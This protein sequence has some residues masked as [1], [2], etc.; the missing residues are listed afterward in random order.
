MK[1]V[2]SVMFAMLLVGYLVMA[3]GA[4]AEEAPESSSNEE[5]IFGSVPE[6]SD[7]LEDSETITGLLIEE[8]ETP[9]SES[10]YLEEDSPLT[11]SSEEQESAPSDSML[12]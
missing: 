6:G 1:K 12:N 7:D 8:T 10:P 4:I 3:S 5:A 9:E 2:V 11:E